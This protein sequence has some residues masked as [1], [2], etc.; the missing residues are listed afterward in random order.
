MSNE[1]NPAAELIDQGTLINT[2]FLTI[3]GTLS[4]GGGAVFSLANGD[5]SAGPE[6]AGRIEDDGLTIKNLGAGET[7]I[8]AHMY[9]NG[10]V[11]VATGSLDF[12]SRLYG[13]GGP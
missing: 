7:A 8:A 1:V 2:A 6:G 5:I 10:V 9:D 3:A 13:T 4:V 12:A 11:E